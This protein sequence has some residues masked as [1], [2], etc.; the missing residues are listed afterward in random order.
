MTEQRRQIPVET[1]D[2]TTFLGDGVLIV[3]ARKP[4]NSSSDKS[5]RSAQQTQQTPSGSGD[6][7]IDKIVKQTGAPAERIRDQISQVW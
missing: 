6:E 5:T 2:P 7:L 4:T 3:G 1:L